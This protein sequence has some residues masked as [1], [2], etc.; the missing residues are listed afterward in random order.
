[1]RGV[2]WEV[3]RVCFADCNIFSGVVPAALISGRIVAVLWMTASWYH[4]AGCLSTGHWLDGMSQ[5]R[6]PCTEK[7]AVPRSP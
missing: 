4:H 1:M 5:Y 6:V 7:Y 3:R 2:W